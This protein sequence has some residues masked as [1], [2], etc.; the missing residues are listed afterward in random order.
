[1]IGL[2]S[3]RAGVQ[4]V[5]GAW[6]PLLKNVLDRGCAGL[7]ESQLKKLNGLLGNDEPE[8]NQQEIALAVHILINQDPSLSEQEVLNRIHIKTADEELPVEGMTEE[9]AQVLRDTIRPEDQQKIMK[10]LSEK[11]KPPPVK[12]A[13]LAKKCYQQSYKK[14]PAKKVQEAVKRK[15]KEEAAQPRGTTSK[16]KPEK[17]PDAPKKEQSRKYAKV[18]E[19]IDKLLQSHLPVDVA[20]ETDGDNGRWRLAHRVPGARQQKSI[21]WTM[22]GAGPA[23]AAALKE[24]FR[25][26]ESQ[27][28]KK[29]PEATAKLVKKW[30]GLPPPERKP[31]DRWQGPAAE[32]AR[33]S[34]E[35]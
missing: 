26:H 20:C 19:T 18:D 21:S 22:V 29:M 27:T 33:S 13:E 7:S 28:G 6:E 12:V 25:W 16:R 17:P 15:K 34:T 23:A 8:A 32:P 10:T 5:A 30:Q 31:E 2:R 9:M 1:M 3:Q 4:V 35:L 11:N 14:I 24:A